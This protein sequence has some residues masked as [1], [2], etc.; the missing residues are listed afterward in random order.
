MGSLEQAFTAKYSIVEPLEILNIMIIKINTTM[1]ET[2]VKANLMAENT[3]VLSLERP[4][5]SSFLLPKPSTLLRFIIITIKLM[6]LSKA[7]NKA[8]ANIVYA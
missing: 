3:F 6:K 8:I 4:Y 5:S 1:Q 7:M 2:R